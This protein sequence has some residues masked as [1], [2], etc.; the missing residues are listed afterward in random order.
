MQ[1]RKAFMSA[2]WTEEQIQE[3]LRLYLGGEASKFEQETGEVSAPFSQS[4]TVMMIQS[5]D[6]GISQPP[7]A[8]LLTPRPTI[9][10]TKY[11]AAGICLVVLVAGGS[12]A[13]LTERS[14]PEQILSAAQQKFAG[15]GAYQEDF[16]MITSTNSPAI[17]NPS[18][19]TSTLNTQSK[20][21]TTMSGNMTVVGND[22]QGSI[23]VSLSSPS[24]KSQGTSSA[25]TID[26]TVLD[27]EVYA[28]ININNPLLAM[29]LHFPKAWIHFDVANP[30]KQFA[31]MQSALAQNQKNIMDLLLKNGGFQI[32]STQS[33]II[34]GE[35][36]TKLVLIATLDTTKLIQTANERLTYDLF[37]KNNHIDLWVSKKDQMIR[38]IQLGGATEQTDLTL[39]ISQLSSPP[40]IVAPTPAYTYDDYLYQT[41]AESLPKTTVQT[42]VLGSYGLAKEDINALQ[43]E[44]EKTFH[45]QIIVL[46]TFGNLLDKSTESGL[47]K[48]KIYDP[49]R[50]QFNAD[51][52]WD[53][54]SH[55][56]DKTND[57]RVR[58]VVIIGQDMY[59]TI[60][61]DSPYVF[62]RSL[63]VTNVILISSA[64]LHDRSD[65]SVGS[66]DQTTFH[67]RLQKLVMRT[68]GVSAGF[69]LSPYAT[70]SHCLMHFSNN[71]MDL[72]AVG[73][74][75][76]GKEADEINHV[77]V[78]PQVAQAPGPDGL[79]DFARTYIVN[80]KKSTPGLTEAQLRASMIN[81]QWPEAQIQA[82]IRL[83]LTPDT[84]SIKSQ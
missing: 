77:F 66:V 64:H 26:T 12:Y 82:G 38:K 79:S 67:D 25:I 13:Y 4:N 31:S 59:S 55:V 53:Y 50:K 80:L 34:N 32:Q 61:K 37:L 8:G 83:Y 76:C 40:S 28:R 74:E 18:T 57:P 63:P 44:I 49:A 70:D 29:L 47:I 84:A 14:T 42:I 33:E 81:A 68:L 7:A 5:D 27:K 30:P 60:S 52:L 15:L 73:K 2:Q 36:M 51:M 69:E 48:S 62:S 24:I 45:T 56:L 21:I 78:T 23:S 11:F 72:D 54:F 35:E 43:K 17:L 16:V 39:T 46:S 41:F 9:S 65:G 3:G 58:Y 22:S 10:Y 19:G 75:F 71:L 20:I 1:L 6:A